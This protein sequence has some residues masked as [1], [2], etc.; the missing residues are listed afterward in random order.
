MH[1]DKD[2]GRDANEGEREANE[3]EREANEG[4]CS[5]K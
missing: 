1:R 2:E 4:C 3:G 5:P